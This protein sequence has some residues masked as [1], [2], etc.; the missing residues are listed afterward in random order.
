MN[1]EQTSGQNG[2]T[3]LHGRGPRSVCLTTKLTA[4]ESQA[5]EEAASQVGKKPSEWAR[6]VLLRQCRREREDFDVICEIVGLQLLVMNVLAPVARGEQIT[7]EHFQRI[8]K[9][10]QAAKVK[11][12]EEMLARRR[13]NED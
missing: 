10:V 8:V 3:K 7:A 12:A 13:A 1:E 5:V 6:E 11:A 2:S 9:S 4:P